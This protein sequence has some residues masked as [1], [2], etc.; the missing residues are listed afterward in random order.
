MLKRDYYEVLGVDKNVIVVEIKKVYR[1]KV[2]QFYFDK[3][4][5][6]KEL[7]EKF[8]EVVEVYEVLSN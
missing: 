6:D 3:N 4:F 7:E 5:D 2:I 1:K 8:K